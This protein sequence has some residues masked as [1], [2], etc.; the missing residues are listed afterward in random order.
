MSLSLVI[1][2]LNEEATLSSCLHRLTDARAASAEVIVV[3]GGSIDNTVAL[4]ISLADRVLAA[5]RGRASQMNAGA[6]GARGDTLLF[7]HADTIAPPR[8]DVLIANALVHSGRAWGFFKVGIVPRTPLL[9][10][11]AFAMNA[12]SHLSGIATGDQAIF[13]RRAVFEA[14]GGY[15]DIPLMEDIAICKALRRFGRPVRVNAR[16]LTSARRWQKKGAVRTI[17]LMWWLRLNYF[18]GTDPGVLARRYGYVPRA[19]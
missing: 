15:P 13:V 7:L 19:R 6:R 5:P 11:V 18:L 8:T 3:D 4:A 17:L 16:V 12:R 2:V 10:L 14:V 9:S 1:P